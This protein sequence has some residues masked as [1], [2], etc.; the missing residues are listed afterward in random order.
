MPMGG[1]ERAMGRHE[2]MVRSGCWGARLH[3]VGL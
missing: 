3:G 2:P 1:H